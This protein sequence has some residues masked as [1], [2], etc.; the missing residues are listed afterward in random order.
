M[1]RRRSFDNPGIPNIPL[2]TGTPSDHRTVAADMPQPLPEARLRTRLPTTTSDFFSQIIRQ[3]EVIAD[4]AATCAFAANQL[5]R[6]V[7]NSIHRSTA[8][9]WHIRYARP[10]RTQ[11]EGSDMP[12]LS[13]QGITEP[14]PFT[15]SGLLTRTSFYF[16]AVQD[17]NIVRA[18][19]KNNPATII[20]GLLGSS[21][22]I[23]MS[24]YVKVAHAGRGTRNSSISIRM[25]EWDLELV[26]SGYLQHMDIWGEG[27]A[28]HPEPPTRASASPLLDDE[29]DEL[30]RDHDILEDI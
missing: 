3:W 10:T 20:I 23:V 2:P 19:L 24:L 22:N 17:A 27:T 15:D 5:N 7:G 25:D 14:T 30:L 21:D 13:S 12:R 29:L 6:A 11:Q 16:N 8:E 1:P 9:Q 28:P 18:R 26:P 4:R